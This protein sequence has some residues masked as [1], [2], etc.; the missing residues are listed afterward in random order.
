MTPPARSPAPAPAS[1][2]P[3]IADLLERVR[4]L[5]ARVRELELAARPAASVAPTVAVAASRRSA[6]PRESFEDAERA[7]IVAALDRARWNKV[8]ASRT[9]GIP[10]R[11]FYRLLD[12]LKIG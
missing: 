2:D 4:G 3:I 8:E 12:R 1:T 7:R 5:E 6:T 10:R 11:T 9:L